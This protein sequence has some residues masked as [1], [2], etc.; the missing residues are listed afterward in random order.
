MKLETIREFVVFARH[1]SF[2]NAARELHMA[3][4]TL[5]VHMSGL[6]KD[7][8]FILIDR[9]VQPFSLTPAGDC[10]LR[11]AQEM[12]KVFKAGCEQSAEL[13]KQENPARVA[14]ISPAVLN[15]VR[16][17]ARFTFVDLDFDVN[18]ITELVKNRADV[19]GSIDFTAS[20]E[21]RELCR[22]E[23]IDYLPV[24]THEL[25]IVMMKTHPLASKIDNLT[26]ADLDGCSAVI[27]NGYFYKYWRLVATLALG[28]NVHLDFRLDN[29]G[30]Q[31]NFCYADFGDSIHICGKATMD[32]FLEGRDDVCMA[33]T[34]DGKPL[35]WQSLALYRH[36][37]KNSNVLALVN[38]LENRGKELSLAEDVWKDGLPGLSDA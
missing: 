12:L 30:S 14:N 32:R 24:Q 26:A 37:A 35:V 3:E 20:R 13:A 18:P 19:I 10:F 8:G 4:P 27:C 1:L 31:S 28:G 33:D 23:G 11:S 29:I 9:S 22:A 36:S 7:L 25:C 15:Q 38:E 5:S 6:E 16:D 34:V 2:R 17:S 21:F